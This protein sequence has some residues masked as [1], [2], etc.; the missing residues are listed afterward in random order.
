MPNYLDRIA[1]VNWLEKAPYIYDSVMTKANMKADPY[2]YDGKLTVCSEDLNIYICDTT[3]DPLDATGYYHKM[4]MDVYEGY[5]TAIK[6]IADYAYEAFYGDLN[7]PYALKKFAEGANINIGGCSSVRKGTLYGRNLDWVYGE[8]AEFI[9]HT[10]SANGRF[11]T[12]GTCG[13]NSALTDAF[14]KSGA[15][16]EEYVMLPFYCTDGINEKGVVINVNVVPRDAS[17][18]EQFIEPQGSTEITLCTNMIPRYVLDY[19]ATAREAV[20]FIRDHMRIYFSPKLHAMHYEAHFMVGDATD[21]FIVEFLNNQVS[22]LDCNERDS[23]VENRPYMTN[24]HL[25]GVSISTST[26]DPAVHTPALNP[27]DVTSTGISLYGAGLERY[28]LISDS[29]RDGKEIAEI[30]DLLKYS[31]A[32]TADTT[33]LTE[34]VGSDDLTVDSAPADF[35][36]IINRAHNKFINRSRDPENPNYGTWHTSHSIIYNMFDKT[37]VAHFQEAEAAYDFELIMPNGGGQVFTDV[38]AL[39]TDL[40]DKDTI[41]RVNEPSND[42]E[43]NYYTYYANKWVRLNYVT[44]GKTIREENGELVSTLGAWRED[45]FGTVANVDT[46]T[47]TEGRTSTIVLKSTITDDVGFAE[48]GTFNIKVTCGDY[49]FNSAIT[50]EAETTMLRLKGETLGLAYGSVAELTFAAAEAPEFGTYTF[51]FSADAYTPIYGSAAD[52]TDGNKTMVLEKSNPEYHKINGNFIDVDNQTITLNEDNQLTASVMFDVG[53]L[54]TEDISES[55]IYRVGSILADSPAKYKMRSAPATAGYTMD[56]LGIKSDSGEYLY[57][58]DRTN[59]D[60][61]YITY[62]YYTQELVDGVMQRIPHTDPLLEVAAAGVTDYV[63]RFTMTDSSGYRYMYKS[64]LTQI[65]RIQL[66]FYKDEKWTIMFDTEKDVTVGSINGVEMSGEQTTESLKIAQAISE[67]VYESKGTSVLTDDIIYLVSD[68]AIDADSN[69]DYEDYENKPALDGVELHNYTTLDDIHVY[70]KTAIDDKILNRLRVLGQVTAIDDL[71]S[72]N[73]EPGDIYYV[74]TEKSYYFYNHAS[75]WVKLTNDEQLGDLTTLTTTNKTNLVAAIN[76]VKTT[77]VLVDGET[78]IRNGSEQLQSIAV[79]DITSFPTEGI[80]SHSIYRIRE[81]EKYSLY[82]YFS[83]K[84]LKIAYGSDLGETSELVTTDKTSAV[85][86]INEVA[87]RTHI[88]SAEPTDDDGN[89]G[90]IWFVYTP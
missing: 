17:N 47:E 35:A 81:G 78:V 21:T 60:V 14:V 79:I 16:S 66:F 69:T 86:A 64:E 50:C 76:E 49:V 32:Y 54:P 44:D 42:G 70:S 59:V 52:W 26:T 3:K 10:P 23:N 90:D 12:L 43:G 40:V 62:T 9:I 57:Q 82:Q 74:L 19:C 37:A 65:D 53:T 36:G 63:T 20:E 72:K 83:N 27:G 68:G 51:A 71:S 55:A 41:Y 8:T 39:P 4:N 30:M 73:P 84:W 34:F 1:G 48:G 25:T 2:A 56:V 28:N 75:A 29:L 18:T 46:A 58:W 85:A 38:D 13:Q 6:P 33:W 87:N 15:Y 88:A 77:S 45:N 22:I 80:K 67:D 31:N 5:Y 24:F 7:Y 61:Q 89:D 11:A